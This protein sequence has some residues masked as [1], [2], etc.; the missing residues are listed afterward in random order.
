MKTE[1]VFGG[2]DALALGQIAPSTINT[3]NM[4]P[5]SV[6]STILKDTD[7]YTVNSLIA[8]TTLK[9]T[10]DL[11]VLGKADVTGNLAVNTNKFTVDATTGNVVIAGDLTVSGTTVTLDATT[12][13]IEDKNIVVGKGGTAATANGSGITV[14]ITDGTDGSV[15]YDATSA[16]KFACG[17]VGTE[18]DIV[19]ATVVQTLTN[20]TVGII[21]GDSVG[22]GTLTV[23]GSSYTNLETALVALN[24]SV[25]GTAQV[26]YTDDTALVGMALTV[27]GAATI[28]A[29]YCS[30]IRMSLGAANDYTVAS[31]VITFTYLPVGNI[32]VDWK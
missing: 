5:D 29:V 14:Q 8:T 13:I 18:D 19:T 23:A 1:T 2:V 24:S 25:G 31:N 7:N 16:S 26:L 10:T 17:P 11:T 32:V 28:S 3:Y 9:A 27:A 30:G 22:A 21:N 4:V 12:L 6:D 20:K 15:V